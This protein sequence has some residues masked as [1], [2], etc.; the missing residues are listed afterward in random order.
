MQR[1]A[2]KSVPSTMRGEVSTVRDAQAANGG[3]LV[4]SVTTISPDWQIAPRTA[5]ATSGGPRRQIGGCRRRD[6]GITAKEATLEIVFSGPSR[7][8][9]ADPPRDKCVVETVQRFGGFVAKY[10]G[11][12]VLVCFG[13]RGLR[14]FKSNKFDPAAHRGSFRYVGSGSSVPIHTF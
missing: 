13:A 6:D 2:S 4:R 12:G 10:M 14:S 7:L 5:I 1:L 9:E 3:Q 8:G 11:D